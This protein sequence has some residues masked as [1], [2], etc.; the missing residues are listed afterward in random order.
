MEFKYWEAM[1]RVENGADI[2]VDA[3]VPESEPVKKGMEAEP[4]KPGDT[5][6]EKRVLE[7][8]SFLEKELKSEIENLTKTENEKE[9]VKEPVREPETE[10]QN[11]NEKETVIIPINSADKASKEK[12]F[13]KD[14]EGENTE[15]KG[16]LSAGYVISKL[17]LVYPAGVVSLAAISCVIA[18]LFALSI[19]LI[20]GTVLSLFGGVCLFFA[21][22]SAAWPLTDAVVLFIGLGVIL[23]A[24]GLLIAI[25]SI[26]TGFGLI[27]KVAALFT[28]ITLWFRFKKPEKVELAD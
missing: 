8:E 2:K 3:P 12:G 21:A 16:N 28:K 20:A 14:K 6:L 4:L 17:L 25:L 11:L 5:S 13:S 24:I 26:L 18:C 9:S 15:R 27:P 23:I 19:V 1:S 10:L 7:A 22:F